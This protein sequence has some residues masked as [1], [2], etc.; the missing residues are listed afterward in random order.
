MCAELVTLVE[1]AGVRTNE[2]AEGTVRSCRR[3]PEERDEIVGDVFVVR[4]RIIGRGRVE[5]DGGY[6]D[7]GRRLGGR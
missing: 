5:I 6:G 7:C 2:V 4:H 3:G 1:A